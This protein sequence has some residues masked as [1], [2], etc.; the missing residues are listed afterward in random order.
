MD[1]AEEFAKL[2]GVMLAP[3][4][5][6]KS[7]YE[8]ELKD[9]TYKKARHQGWLPPEVRDQNAD[10]PADFVFNHEE[11]NAARAVQAL[12][13][14]LP[15]ASANR[16]LLDAV[17]KELQHRALERLSRGDGLKSEHYSIHR[18]G[19]F[20]ILSGAGIRIASAIPSKGDKPSVDDWKTALR[21]NLGLIPDTQT[22]HHVIVEVNGRQIGATDK[23]VRITVANARMSEGEDVA[24]H[25]VFTQEG[26]VTDLTRGGNVIGSKSEMYGDIGITLDVEQRVDQPQQN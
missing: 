12:P 14:F 2:H 17:R 24:L 10:D 7:D 16:T 1:W 8:V 26:V 25:S 18:D 13:G 19:R 21:S 11:L 22:E 3:I 6:S 5:L 23:E 15:L 4:A 20:H 9:F